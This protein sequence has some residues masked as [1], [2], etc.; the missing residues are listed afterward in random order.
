MKARETA[1]KATENKKF[2]KLGF[3][4]YIEYWRN[5]MVKCEGFATVFGPY[6]DY[7]IRVLAELDKPLLVTP[8]K[9][10]EDFWPCHDWRV[11]QA[12]VSRRRCSSLIV[13]EDVTLE[14]EEPEPYCGLANEALE[15]PFNPWHDIRPG[16]WILLRHE[17]PLIYPVWQGKAVSVVCREKRDVNLGKFLLQF[18]EPKSTDR[19]LA[20]KYRNYWSAKWI[21][22][23][24]A[25]EWV[26]FDSMIYATWS[27][28]MDLGVEL[29]LRK[30]WNVH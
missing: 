11:F 12:K 28:I 27:K 29:F 5:G 1:A 7:W 25:P 20:L 9:L 18:W 30:P 6:I 14:D 8:P 17:D 16:S 21:V 23:K 15:T 22:E 3:H 2:M 24:R 13:V 19:D 10:V 26:I 4:K